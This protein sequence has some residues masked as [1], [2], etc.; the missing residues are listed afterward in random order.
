M[1]SWQPTAAVN[2]FVYQAVSRSI[3]ARGDI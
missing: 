1:Q 3:A 2:G